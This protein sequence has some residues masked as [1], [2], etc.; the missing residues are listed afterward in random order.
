M[1]SLCS[2]LSDMGQS[3]GS[4]SGSKYEGFQRTA[5]KTFADQGILQGKMQ[6]VSRQ[7]GAVLQRLFG[8]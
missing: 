8:M 5:T 4:V 6:R 3:K 2:H 7:H 1:L